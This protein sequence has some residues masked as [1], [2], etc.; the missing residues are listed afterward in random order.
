MILRLLHRVQTTSYMVPH[1]APIH[2]TF[3]PLSMQRS[4]SP[5]PFPCCLPFGF[6]YGTVVNSTLVEFG[7]SYS[8][9][10]ARILCQQLVMGSCAADTCGW[11]YSLSRNRWYS[12]SPALTGEPPNYT[13]VN[14]QDN[15]VDHQIH[16]WGIRT[17]SPV[18]T[19]I[20]SRL[21][22]LSRLPGPTAMTLASLSFSTLDSGRKM[23]LAVLASALT[24]WTRTRSKRG[25]RARMDRIEVACA[26]GQPS[27]CRE[28]AA[29][30]ARPVRTIVIRKLYLCEVRQRET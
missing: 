26:K 22:F 1:R 14:I 9:I 4:R 6:R 16:T 25:A 5:S 13:P 30:L 17:R 21:P 12:S 28:V 20:G 24:R 27:A 15:R 10:L 11:T 2:R 3:T 18:L 8:L 7:V 19:P 29:G 23:P